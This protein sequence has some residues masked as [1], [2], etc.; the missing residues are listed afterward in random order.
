MQKTNN[1][2]Y[3]MSSIGIG[4]GIPL[5][6]A[7]S[8]WSPADITTELWLDASDASTITE[9]LGLV[10]EWRD[11]S[12][13]NNDAAQTVAASQPQ[14]GV[15]T[16]GGN[17]AITFSKDFLVLDPSVD[18]SQYKNQELF[19]VMQANNDGT[20]KGFFTQF[21]GASN[22][23]IHR[24]NG[25][26]MKIA[27]F[28]QTSGIQVV[29][30][31][32]SSLTSDLIYSA[33]ANSSEIAVKLSQATS[34]TTASIP[35]SLANATSQVGIGGRS[36]GINTFNG[37]IGELVFVPNSL[38]SDDRYRMEGY[39]SWKWGLESLL[40]VGHPYKLSPP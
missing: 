29:E 40:P 25:D 11:K 7:S 38:S 4:I 9:S 12:G 37:K 27:F 10:S 21:D 24:Y 28:A 35:Q 13:S 17:N 6:G 31:P 18:F 19:A 16:I 33:Y 34:Y 30:T 14:T 3:I 26:T 8:G 1:I 23:F 5:G 22:C 2:F 36:N 39:L 15:D 32:Q 20:D